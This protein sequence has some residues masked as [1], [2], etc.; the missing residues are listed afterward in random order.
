[1][2]G[3]EPAGAR[4]LVAHVRL[5]IVQLAVAASLS[6]ACNAELACGPGT[7]KRNGLCIPAGET[8]GGTETGESSSGGASNLTGVSSADDDENE[9][10]G[11]AGSWIEPP[12]ADCF[13]GS[14]AEC[15]DGEQ[16]IASLDTCASGCAYD[17][18]CPD[19]SDGTA[20]QRCESIAGDWTERCV[21]YCGVEGSTCPTGMVCRTLELCPDD[22]G[23]STGYGDSTGGCEPATLPICVWE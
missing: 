15:S 16:C 18:D 20:V 8:D 21:L 22:S 10:A 23:G 11:S 9:V 3:R 12:Y 1:V 13:A 5:T 2:C 19:P 14:D 17:T 4:R 7:E 6:S